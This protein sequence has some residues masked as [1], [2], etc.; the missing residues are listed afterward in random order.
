ME[1]NYELAKWLAGDMSE[2]ELK[3]FQKTPEFETY[4]KIAL[5]S[6]QLEA[7]SF[8]ENKMY[9]NVISKNKKTVKWNIRR[10]SDVNSLTRLSHIDECACS[11]NIF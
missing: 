1:E 8:D 9:E 3:A 11:R 2:A 7:P 5:Y 10:W 4:H 6:S